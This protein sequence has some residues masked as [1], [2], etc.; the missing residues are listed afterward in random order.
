MTELTNGTWVLVADGE[1]AMFLENVTDGEDPFLKVRRLESQDNPR[2]GEQT[3]DRAGRRGD[4]GAGQRS[5][6]EETDWHVLAKARF[7]HD[8]ADILYKQAHR[9]AFDRIVLVAPPRTLGA[10]RKELHKEVAERVAAE[11]PKDVTNHP[12]PEIEKL[13]KAALADG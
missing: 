11:L 1:K 2:D 9:G 6:M 10:L 12:I 7:A 3:S 4:G 13:V 8:L 5:A